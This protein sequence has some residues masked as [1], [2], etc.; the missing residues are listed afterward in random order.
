M[1]A[2][3]SAGSMIPTALPD[4]LPT[5]RLTVAARPLPPVRQE[6]RRI[7]DAGNAWTVTAAWVQSL[8]VIVAAAAINRG[9][10]YVAAFLLM[11]RG[12][13]LLNI[14]SHEAAHRLLFSRRRAND[15]IGRWALAYPAFMPLDLYRRAHMAHHR[16][17]MGPHEPDLGLYSGYPVTRAS[18]TRKLIRD[19]IGISGWKN[20]KPLLRGL[21]RAPSRG[22]AARIVG[23]QVV[24]AVA[25]T[26]IGLE[27]D[28]IWWLYPVLWLAPWLTAWRVINRL[29]AIAEH[30]GMAR[31][32]DRRVTTHV[33]RQTPLARFWMVPY[34]TGWHLAHHVDPGIP[35]R[36][37]PA[38]HAE[39]E[40][41]GWV[42]PELTY[43]TYRELWAALAS[44]ASTA[45]SSEAG[46]SVPDPSG[47]DPVTAR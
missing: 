12:F 14:L 20:L 19:S 15:G 5:D 46:P 24:V 4:V 22:V 29:R 41:A 28:G 31:S 26:V 34:R 25:L 38:L 3:V 40:A 2:T 47:A 9:W 8:G 45:D 36:N 43:R 30:G 39:L 44:R 13:A 7:S 37:L 18:L 23:A 17:E 27:L 16:D 35:W 42:T 6:L 11:G 10:A 1:V 32:E 33:I 21:T